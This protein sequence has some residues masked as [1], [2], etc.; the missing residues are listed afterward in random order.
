MAT[1][2]ASFSTPHFDNWINYTKRSEEGKTP[3]AMISSKGQSIAGLLVESL[4]SANTI[5]IIDFDISKVNSTDNGQWT[6][7]YGFTEPQDVVAKQVYLEVP[8]EDFD[9]DLTFLNSLLGLIWFDG[10]NELVLKQVRE[11]S[12]DQEIV[13]E[14]RII[15]DNKRLFK[16]ALNQELPIL[17]ARKKEVKESGE[18]EALAEKKSILKTEITNTEKKPSKIWLYAMGFVALGGVYLAYRK[19]TSYK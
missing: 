15:Q 5:E 16:L 7:A 19:S 1:I 18:L 17:V 13:D 8:D 4:P 14:D 2:L 10:E 12:L 11:T 9:T 6:E 3:S